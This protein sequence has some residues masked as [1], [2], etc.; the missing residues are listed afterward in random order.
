M[1]RFSASLQKNVKLV[2]GQ[3]EQALKASSYLEIR[4]WGIQLMGCWIWL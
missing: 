1:Y 2:H 3:A 4:T